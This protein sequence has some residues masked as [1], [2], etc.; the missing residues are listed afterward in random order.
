MKSIDEECLTQE[1]SIL[2]LPYQR[3]VLLPVN[4][5][6]LA[7]GYRYR[8]DM[9]VSGLVVLELKAVNHLEPIHDAQ[10]LTYLK[11]STLKLGLLINFNVP[12]IKNGIRHLVFGL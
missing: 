4:Y 1:L 6:G 10:L 5:K 8:S 7:L 11:L 2:G 3:Q 12:L 9:V